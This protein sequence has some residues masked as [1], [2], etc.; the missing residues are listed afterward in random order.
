M[1]RGH[2]FAA[3]RAC[4]RWTVTGSTGPLD[5]PA[6]EH[7]RESAHAL[8][9]ARVTRPS[10]SSTNMNCPAP[11]T[12]SSGCVCAPR[13]SSSARMRSARCRRLAAPRCVRAHRRTV[14]ALS[15]PASRRS[16]PSTATPRG[17]APPM[18][19]IRSHSP[20]LTIASRSR[21]TNATPPSRAAAATRSGQSF[22]AADRYIRL[23]DGGIV[24]EVR[25]LRVPVNA[26]VAAG[27]R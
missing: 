8:A 9:P 19:S 16:S 10:A 17:R 24:E 5:R 26:P 21:S 12:R 14:R 22:S 6:F 11:S 20:T 2:A 23:E 13:K 3:M 15:P 4:T 27:R 18:R 7:G 1:P 25:P